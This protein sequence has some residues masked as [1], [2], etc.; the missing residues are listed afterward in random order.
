MPTQIKM[1]VINWSTLNGSLNKKIPN[2]NIIVGPM[3][4]MNPV[5]DNGILRAPAEKSISG[6]A[7]TAPEKINQKDEEL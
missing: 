4:C 6:I 2:T 3:Y 1:N 5:S 7:V